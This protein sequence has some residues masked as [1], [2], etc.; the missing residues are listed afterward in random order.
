MYYLGVLRLILINMIETTGYVLLSGWTGIFSLGHAG[1]IAVGAYTSSLLIMRAGLPWSLA[2]I[3]GGLAAGIVSIP[4]GKASL[5]LKAGYFAICSL[6]LGETIR[7]I[8]N[9]LEVIGGSRGIPGVP[10]HFANIYSILIVFIIGLIIMI[11]LRRSKFG[12]QCVAVRDDALAAEAMG[13]NTARVKEISLFISA[14]YC[15]IGGAFYASYLSFIQPS[16]F[17]SAMSSALSTWVVFGGLGSLTGGLLG[18]FIITAITETFRAF[19][20]YRMFFYGLAL[21]VIIAIRPRGLIGTWELTPGNVKGL[22]KKV[23]AKRERKHC[24]KEEAG[25]K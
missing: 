11:N 4:I 15:G 14:V 3:L 13:I 5:R 24:K 2:I 9:N 21:V 12:R 10:T 18:T 20:D 6:A 19:A 22:I 25:T 8:L 16:S 17:S 7:L 1:F 23:S